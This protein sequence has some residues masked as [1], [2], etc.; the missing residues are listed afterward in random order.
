MQL[1]GVGSILYRAECDKGGERIRE[2]KR[3]TRNTSVTHTDY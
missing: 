3:M 2:Q 1:E